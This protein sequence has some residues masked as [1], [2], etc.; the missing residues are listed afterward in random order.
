[1]GGKKRNENDDAFDAAL[2]AV[3]VDIGGIQRDVNGNAEKM[4]TVD[5]AKG[6]SLLAPFFTGTKEQINKQRTKASQKIFYWE[7]SPKNFVISLKM[8]EEIHGLWHGITNDRI[9]AVFE[10]LRSND[11]FVAAFQPLPDGAPAAAIV[12][13]DGLTQ[14]EYEQMF[15]AYHDAVGRGG[16]IHP[17]TVC[18]KL[19]RDEHEAL[20]AAWGDKAKKEVL[21]KIINHMQGAKST[22]PSGGRK[23]YEQLCAAFHVIPHPLRTSTTAT[24]TATTNNTT[25]DGPP[26]RPPPPHPHVGHHLAASPDRAALSDWRGS[27][28]RP[29]LSDGYPLREAIPRPLFPTSAVKNSHDPPIRPPPPYPHVGQYPAALP[30]WPAT[31]VGSEFSDGLPEDPP[32]MRPVE[33]PAGRHLQHN[34]VSSMSRREIAFGQPSEHQGDS[35]YGH[36][37]EVWLTAK[38]EKRETAMNQ[39]AA[40]TNQAIE[41]GTHLF[42]NRRARE[43]ETF[44]LGRAREDETFRLEYEYNAKMQARLQANHDDLQRGLEAGDDPNDPIMAITK[45]QLESIQKS[46]EVHSQLDVDKKTL[47]NVK[48]N[49][50]I[51]LLQQQVEDNKRRSSVGIEQQQDVPV[52]ISQ[53]NVLFIQPASLKKAP[54]VAT[55]SNFASMPKLPSVPD[56]FFEPT[57]P[58]TIANAARASWSPHDDSST[59]QEDS[60]PSAQKLPARKKTTV[61]LATISENM[62]NIPL[63]GSLDTA[64]LSTAALGSSACAGTPRSPSATFGSPYSSTPD[65]DYADLSDVVMFTPNYGLLPATPPSPARSHQSMD[66][67]NKT[68][69]RADVT[70][71]GVK[72]AKSG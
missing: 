58:A 1:M 7:K 42:G 18:T 34:N 27:P 61:P 69:R 31:P 13:P 62:G 5:A 45:K 66:N 38:K 29:E 10:Y 44:R 20:R 48:A 6:L 56:G 59:A 53:A 47:E 32:T 68:R 30:E 57:E 24:M 2:A 36:I 14:V 43:D 52:T 15:Y 46:Q 40:N 54:P 8:A 33:T 21:S 3:I 55:S 4:N 50:E 64:A 26:I 51:Q 9:W 49:L 67:N 63:L 35:S 12:L 37:L 22:N 25:A 16:K 11:D 72:M 23:T 65:L 71:R 60:K 19:S 17:S 41:L 70:D 39:I 28:I